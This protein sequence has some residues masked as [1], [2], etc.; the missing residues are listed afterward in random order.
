MTG[1]A[2]MPWARELSIRR[3]F[4]DDVVV[5]GV[6]PLGHLARRNSTAALRMTFLRLSRTA[7]RHT[8]IIVQHIALEASHA[9]RQ[10]AQ[11]ETHVQH[12]IVE[13][14]ITDRHEIEAGLVLPVALAKFRA[15]GFKCVAGRLTLPVGFEGE[16]QFAFGSDPWKAKVMDDCHGLF[17]RKMNRCAMVCNLP[18]E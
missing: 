3:E 2:L 8:K 5:V 6:E 18:H 16:F 9:F 15:F 13:R 7:T 12:L 4:R 11:S 14:K 17:L 10:I 1:F